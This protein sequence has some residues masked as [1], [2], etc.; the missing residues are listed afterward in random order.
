MTRQRFSYADR[1]LIV[2]GEH[3]PI[4]ARSS[5]DHIART[6]HASGA[7]L[8]YHRYRGTGHF[9]LIAAAHAK[10]AQWIETR[11]A[12]MPA[13]AIGERPQGHAAD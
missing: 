3:D 9:D 6:L 12:V 5:T 4:V 11:L 13:Q 1:S 7:M 10:N 2:Q 8:D